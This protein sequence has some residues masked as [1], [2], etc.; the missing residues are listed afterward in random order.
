MT[1]TAAE[2]ATVI[3]FRRRTVLPLDACLGSLRAYQ[4]A[5]QDD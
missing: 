1:L 3:E 4:S 2:E 5:L